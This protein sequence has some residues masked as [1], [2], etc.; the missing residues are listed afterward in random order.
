[1]A[2]FYPTAFGVEAWGWGLMPRGNHFCGAGKPRGD[3]C[4]RLQHFLFDRKQTEELPRACER[5]SGAG[6]MLTPSA[7]VLERPRSPHN[8]QNPVLGAGMGQP[9]PG[10]SQRC[11]RGGQQFQQNAFE[12]CRGASPRATHA[13]CVFFFGRCAHG[14]WVRGM[15]TGSAPTG[16]GHDVAP[17]GVAA[18]GGGRP[19]TGAGGS[20]VRGQGHPQILRS[21]P[22]RSSS[23][24]PQAV[25]TRP[26]GFGPW[27]CH[28]GP[29]RC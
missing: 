21:R 14:G 2:A 27:M 20:G 29:K 11:P 5:G 15:G 18:G 3:G 6:S 23:G 22:A 8:P 13:S 7:P 10:Y 26:A 9:D 28:G 1:M 19:Q 25:S 16:G 4:R 17:G 12:T 24:S